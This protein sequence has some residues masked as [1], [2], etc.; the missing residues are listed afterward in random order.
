MFDKN[1]G[2][3][4]GDQGP[5]VTQV[6]YP[7]AL[8]DLQALSY[9]VG[10]RAL[11][12]IQDAFQEIHVVGLGSGTDLFTDSGPFQFRGPFQDERFQGTLGR[13][14]RE[15]ERAQVVAGILE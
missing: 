8:D 14:S 15:I 10:D 12:S 13:I 1:L 9:L 2:F 6:C 7:F 11:P 5:Y 3:L 4:E